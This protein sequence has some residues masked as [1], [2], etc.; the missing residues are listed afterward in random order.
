MCLPDHAGILYVM[1]V[2]QTPPYDRA[3]S[4]HPGC[5]SEPQVG[6]TVTSWRSD[7]C[8]GQE[9]KL[10]NQGSVIKKIML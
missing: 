9:E 6:K 7:L 2:E 4:S 1:T 10:T 5:L 8:E 3:V